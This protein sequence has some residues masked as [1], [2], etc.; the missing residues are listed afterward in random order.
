M[1]KDYAALAFTDSGR[2][3]FSTQSSTQNGY[4]DELEMLYLLI[5]AMN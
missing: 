1:R 5:N 4:K 3:G 2:L